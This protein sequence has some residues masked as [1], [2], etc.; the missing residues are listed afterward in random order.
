MAAAPFVLIAVGRRP[1]TM[2]GL[3]ALADLVDRLGAALEFFLQALPYSS[4]RQLWVLKTPVT[5]CP[6]GILAD[7]AAEPVP[8]PPPLIPVHC[9]PAT[10]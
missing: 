3:L 4:Y 2:A 10:W 7:M 1:F 8:A 5:L 9:A 6:L